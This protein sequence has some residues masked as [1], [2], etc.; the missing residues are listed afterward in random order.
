VKDSGDSDEGE[1]T[2]Y[3][4]ELLPE[5]KIEG[6]RGRDEGKV[7]FPRDRHEIQKRK[8]QPQPRELGPGSSSATYFSV[9]K[10][11]GEPTEVIEA[12]A[13]VVSPPP[14]SA[15]R[16]NGGEA[17][18]DALSLLAYLHC[19]K[20]KDLKTDS[21]SSDRNA[22]IGDD[23]DDA[24][25]E[26]KGKRSMKGKGPDTGSGSSKPSVIDTPDLLQANP[27]VK[28]GRIKG[29][30]RRETQE[31]IVDQG[32]SSRLAEESPLLEKAISDALNTGKLVSVRSGTKGRWD[33]GLPKKEFK[34]PD[35]GALGHDVE[36][37]SDRE[38]KVR[39]LKPEKAT[40]S[41]AVPLR[42]FEGNRKQVLEKDGFPEEALLKQEQKHPE[43][44]LQDDLRNIEL[45]K[46]LE[47]RIQ[48]RRDES[49]ERD[50]WRDDDRDGEGKRFYR[51]D[52]QRDERLKDQRQKDDEHKD[53]KHRDDKHKDD[54]YREEKDI[55]DR[56]KDDKLQ[57]NKHRERR[58][59]REGVADKYDNKH[60]REGSRVA[61]SRY[62]ENKH[63]DSD[64]D[65]SSHRD[66][67]YS[68]NR[69]Q[70]DQGRLSRTHE[71]SRETK[72]CRNKVTVAEGDGRG[73]DTGHQDENLDHE[74]LPLVLLNSQ[75]GD[76]IDDKQIKRL[77]GIGSDTDR[78]EYRFKFKHL[79]S[80][81]KDKL[82]EE[83]PQ[84]TRNDRLRRNIEQLRGHSR[85]PGRLHCKNKAEKKLD[86]HRDES[87]LGSARS[88]AYDGRTSPVLSHVESSP[89]TNGGFSP[90][91]NVMRKSPSSYIHE[92]GHSLSYE[93][94]S[95]K[96]K[97]ETGNSLSGAIGIH[98]QASKSWLCV[99]AP[100]NDKQ[101][102]AAD[103]IGCRE[104]QG[105]CKSSDDH[106]RSPSTERG[107]DSQIN[108]SFTNEFSKASS[109]YASGS[110]VGGH[111][112]SRR[113]PSSGTSASS[114][115]PS[116]G[117][118]LE[119]A[120]S[121][122]SDWTAHSTPMT[123][124]MG[125]PIRPQVPSLTS[126][127]SGV[128]PPPPPFRPG[129][130]NPAI[131]G[132]SSTG[133]EEVTA[134]RDQR[135]A[136]RQ[137]GGHFKREVMGGT[138]QDVWKGVGNWNSLSQGQ[139]PGNMF[140]PFQHHMGGHPHGGFLNM[141]QQFPGPPLF[142]IRPSPDMG[143]VRYHMRDGGDAFSG[144]NRTFGWQRQ[145]DDVCGPH[146]QVPLHGWDG[147]TS[148]GEEP[149]VYG[150]PARDQIVQG[151]GARSWDRGTDMWK[152]NARDTD[153][154]WGGPQLPRSRPEKI[155][156]ERSPTESIEIKRSDDCPPKIITENQSSTLASNV[157][158][159]CKTKRERMSGYLSK[160]DIS[161]GLAGPELYNDC[162]R[163]IDSKENV[164]SISDA[165]VMMDWNTEVA[166]DNF[167][168]EVDA[169]AE[170][171]L[172]SLNMQSKFFPSLP[173][174]TFERAL[175]HY[176]NA[177]VEIKL[178]PV[179]KSYTSHGA[180]DL[181]KVIVASES[182]KESFCHTKL[183][184]K[185]NADIDV[186]VVC[187]NTSTD[188][189]ST[190]EFTNSLE[191][192]VKNNTQTDQENPYM[193]LQDDAKM[194]NSISPSQNSQ[195]FDVKEPMVNVKAADILL[196][197]GNTNSK[198]CS[199]HPL[200]D[201]NIRM[202]SAEPEDGVSDPELVDGHDPVGFSEE[203]N[204]STTVS[205]EELTYGINSVH[206][207]K[208]PA[209]PADA[210]VFSEEQ[211]NNVDP[212]H[213]NNAPSLVKRNISKLNM[214]EDKTMSNRHTGNTDFRVTER[215]PRDFPVPIDSCT[216][217]ADSN[218]A[219]AFLETASLLS[220]KLVRECEGESHSNS[221]M[222]D[223]ETV[224]QVRE[225]HERHD[226]VE[227]DTV[228]VRCLD[229]NQQDEDLCGE[230]GIQQDEL[231]GNT[232]TALENAVESV[233]SKIGIRN[234]SPYNLPGSTR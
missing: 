104:P 186:T 109:T 12:D 38:K 45:E 107:H 21:E 199:E 80:E 218:N 106:R 116:K 155:R 1:N 18:G 102:F 179:A 149:H 66:D 23:K 160:L 117:R 135:R 2:R 143:G 189:A 77:R 169:D 230:A 63:Y 122:R 127:P 118:R 105:I 193:V 165:A 70:R 57:D 228:S 114:E 154:S 26:D 3:G 187:D 129:I 202:F 39:N 4:P 159:P 214:E 138:G 91:V 72:D 125:S 99:D 33:K 223:S 94:T 60:S 163:T 151:V 164:I 81:S 207:S 150:R 171:I 167:Q 55:E 233:D 30:R 8:S 76:G 87:P 197:G 136:D 68:Q 89:K 220:M 196:L 128:L 59:S 49:G 17:Q 25:I 172:N 204:L 181:H 126:R 61:D 67:R 184:D 29:S 95:H 140:I 232:E 205:P 175:A 86:I 32:N 46:E 229:P 156:R 108:S 168:L 203:P 115:R 97:S 192:A 231:P 158:K 24:R 31:S 82:A 112:D 73:L 90:P 93:K 47:N 215:S 43:W 190:I 144:H 9:K 142:G 123:R 19:S 58:L 88:S 42:N 27:N 195:I 183:Y 131:L 225:F 100:N 5:A 51:D 173:R 210:T 198:V 222:F 110:R 216:E 132:P 50:R 65:Y 101:Q 139:G 130:D 124:A 119:E 16:W 7:D 148:Y 194:N 133:F 234:F 74:K 56:Y 141:A 52:P 85:E 20:D 37:S 176:K 211:A 188:V 206:V 217:I 111:P 224:S 157:P 28:S 48:R 201:V 11:R 53:D 35:E 219:A 221:M 44:Q 191:H 185:T 209:D 212:M 182:S 62:K 113:I 75:A 54:K 147:P 14:L 96:S 227:L 213:T 180:N 120:P 121:G 226:N 103:G 145:A 153:E 134:I 208:V 152:V 98:H 40:G 69:D 170:A 34:D 78:E 79:E 64:R 84:R 15:D 22:G 177:Y 10:K 174:D 137:V 92:L 41:L 200:D 83:K 71:D 178:E 6:K 162:V 161:A 36:W 166:I 13:S 146:I